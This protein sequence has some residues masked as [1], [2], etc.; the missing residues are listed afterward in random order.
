VT[1]QQATTKKTEYEKAWIAYDLAMKSFHKKDYGK[2]KEGL[3]SFAEDFPKEK[4]LID[5]AN[6]YLQICENRLNPPKDTEKTSEDYLQSG[7][8]LMN[9]G[10]FAESLASLEK[11]H[12]KKPKNAKILYTL[13]DVS[14]RKKDHDACLDYLKQA[15]ELDSSLAVLALNEQDFEPL[16]E[17]TRF[18]EITAKG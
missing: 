14:C 18:L 12:G 17:D 9:Q 15:V 10:L 3:G 2:A 13:A 6:I 11:A 8:I 1:A 7:I 16:K 4:E 5:R